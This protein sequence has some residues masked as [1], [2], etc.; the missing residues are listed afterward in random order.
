MV[1]DS[2]RTIAEVA[3]ELGLGARLL[4][5]RVRAEKENTT[6][7]PLSVSEREELRQPKRWGLVREL[8]APDVS[9][10]GCVLE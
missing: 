1:I 6:P 9:A 3:A 10:R 4:G 2:G 5:K 8:V 7:E